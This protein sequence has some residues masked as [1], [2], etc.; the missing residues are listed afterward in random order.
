MCGPRNVMFLELYDA[1]IGPRK[2]EMKI[3]LPKVTVCQNP[4]VLSAIRKL[5]GICKSCNWAPK[6]IFI[7]FAFSFDFTALGEHKNIF[8]N[9][10]AN[11]DRKSLSVLTVTQT[12]GPHLY[13]SLRL[14]QSIFNT[15]SITNWI[16]RE[17]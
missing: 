12:L 1:E 17:K 5:G 10:T 13:V 16:Y 3:Q 15:D 8:D 6:T 2:K 14:F 7:S 9:P 4:P 11:T